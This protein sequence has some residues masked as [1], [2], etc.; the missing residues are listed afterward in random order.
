VYTRPGCPR[1]SRY[2]FG[3]SLAET[4]KIRPYQDSDAP[5]LYT[6]VRESLVE[7]TEWM[8]WAHAEYMLADATA[9]IT[10]AQNGHADG[11]IYDFAIVGGDGRYLGGCGLNQISR[12]NAVAN[13]GYWVRATAMGRGVA[14]KAV[15]LLSDWAF[16]NTD[17]NRLEILAAVKNVRSQRVA[18]KAGAER[19]GVL[20]KRLM[21]HGRTT[22]AVLY[23]IV[24]GD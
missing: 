5:E 22:D 21:L 12:F 18:E 23:S 8:P 14:V 3:S 19:D 16:R 20:R 4:I 2:A 11:S 1:Q 24:R 7:L 13:L 15:K 17:L 10:T 9:W 6:A